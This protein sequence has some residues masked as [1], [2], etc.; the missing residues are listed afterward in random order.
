ME[1]VRVILHVMFG[2]G[3]NDSHYGANGYVHLELQE[4]AGVEIDFVSFSGTYLHGNDLERFLRECED[5]QVIVLDA[6]NH[7]LN[8]DY[9]SRE[10]NDPHES[11]ARIARQISR[12]NPSAQ[13]FADL[14][15]SFNKVAVHEIAEPIKTWTDKKIVGAIKRSVFK[16]GQ[17]TVL[18]FDDTE[19]H[20]DAADEQ[21]SAYNLVIARTYDKAETLIAKKRFDYVL[22]DLLV[23]ASDKTLGSKGKKY[24]GQEMP[25][26]PLLAFLALKQGIKKIGILTD[27]NHHDHPASAAVDIFGSPF[28]IGNAKIQ[29][30]NRGVTSE[31]VKDWKGLMDQLN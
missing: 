16:K 1:K 28:V 8:K 6:W 22:L 24:V 5:A 17:P 18:V 9:G 29:I 21:L 23:P 19:K 20:Q 27:A 15:E 14:M 31:G 12:I 7:P 10:W 11:M 3:S 26:T 2:G 4:K 25:L 13:I 30:S